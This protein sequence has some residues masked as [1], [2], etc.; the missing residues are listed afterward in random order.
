MSRTSLIRPRHTRAVWDRPAPGT[1]LLP[2]P[3][4][5]TVSLGFPL[6]SDGRSFDCRRHSPSKGLCRFGAPSSGRLLLADFTLAEDISASFDA[7]AR[8]LV[9]LSGSTTRCNW[10]FPFGPPRH[11]AVMPSHAAV[12]RCRRT[13]NPHPETPS[14]SV[15]LLRHAWGYRRTAAGA[16]SVG[17]GV[18]VFLLTSPGPSIASPSFAPFPGSARNLGLA[19]SPISA[20]P[21]TQPK[22]RWGGPFPVGAGLGACLKSRITPHFSLFCDL[23]SCLRHLSYWSRISNWAVFNGLM[24]QAPRACPVPS[25]RHPRKEPAYLLTS[26]TLPTEQPKKASFFQNNQNSC[27]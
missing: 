4:F 6:P 18:V 12:E 22:S 5:N 27:L 24:R 2:S 20:L 10:R 1:R 19:H 8:A 17:A 15:C 23:D 25:P 9:P 16:T 13:D 7:F 14:T 21:A 11:R 3:S 26:P